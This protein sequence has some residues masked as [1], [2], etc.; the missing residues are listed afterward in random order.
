MGVIE[1]GLYSEGVWDG[2]EDFG[3]AV[4]FVVRQFKS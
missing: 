4:T 2:E 1:K 3:K